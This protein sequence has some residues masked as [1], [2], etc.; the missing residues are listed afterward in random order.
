VFALLTG[1]NHAYLREDDGRE[2]ELEVR[3]H[4]P[5][6]RLVGDPCPEAGL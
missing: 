4:F 3:P 5:G 2:W 1:V 6:Y